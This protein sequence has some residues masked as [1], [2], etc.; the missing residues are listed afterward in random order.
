MALRCDSYGYDC[1]E[2]IGF[3][4]S[5]YNLKTQLIELAWTS[6]LL[7]FQAQISWIQGDSKVSRE[8]ALTD[9]KNQFSVG[10]G[11]LILKPII[12]IITSY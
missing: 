2:S 3:A 11:M 1:F 7:G 6:S 10:E 5:D 4:L 12:L 9:F 8:C